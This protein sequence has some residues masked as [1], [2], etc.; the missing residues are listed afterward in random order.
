MIGIST[1]GHLNYERQIDAKILFKGNRYSAAVYLMGYAI[2]LALKRKICQNLQFNLGFPELNAEFINYRPQVQ[3]YNAGDIPIAL[4]KLNQI[5]SQKLEDLLDF[6]G[7]SSNIS[8][9]YRKEWDVV[10]D[11]NPEDRYKIRHY[12]TKKCRSFMK[13]ARI[14]LNQINKS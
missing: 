11:W 2:E 7:I 4:N 13:S 6:S 5:K 12:S 14:I 10:R 1:L 3:A 8:D 9:N